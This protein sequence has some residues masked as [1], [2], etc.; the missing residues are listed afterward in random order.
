MPDTITLPVE[1]RRHTRTNLQMTLRSIRLDPDCGDV[2]DCLHMQNI[3]R[4]GLGVISDRAFYAGQ[5]VVLC[6]SV[7]NGGGRKN[8]YARV[9]RCQRYQQAYA[10]GLEFETF[11]LGAWCGVSG[12]VA[13]A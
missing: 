7:P 11:A 9:V 12:N 6:L 10:V 13:A 5:R 4:S 1:R 2:V 8:V 3:S